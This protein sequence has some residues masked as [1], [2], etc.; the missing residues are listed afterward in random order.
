MRAELS[1]NT[2]DERSLVIWKGKTHWWRKKPKD[3]TVTKTI[4]FNLLS[5]F[6]KKKKELASD[7]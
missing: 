5:A 4:T 3:F 2:H 6:T 7:Y 1:T